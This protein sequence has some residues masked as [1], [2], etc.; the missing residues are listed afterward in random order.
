MVINSLI[1]LM[2]VFWAVLTLWSALRSRLDQ[3]ARVPVYVKYGQPNR[4][5]GGE[6][7]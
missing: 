2:L 5:S 7:W 6:K 3:P 4:W 1:M